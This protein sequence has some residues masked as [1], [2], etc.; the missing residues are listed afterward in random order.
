MNVLNLAQKGIDIM[1][2]LANFLAAIAELIDIVL[3]LYMFII[4]G[5]VIISWVGADPYNPIVRFLISATEPV[6][7]PIRRRLPVMGGVDFAPF[8]LL[9]SIIFV[10]SF[11]V[12]SLIQFARSL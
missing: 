4:F 8:I 3:N 12:Q 11:V 7:S 2:V 9:L 10:K 1:Y 6:L 5:R